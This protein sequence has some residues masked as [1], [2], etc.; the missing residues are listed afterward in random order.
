[1]LYVTTR[2]SKDAYT[3]RH[4]LTKDRGPDGGFFIP[5]RKICFTGE[6][7][8]SLGEKSFGQCVAE[9]LNRFFPGKLTGW[10]VDF[11]LGRRPIRL[12]AMSHKILVGELFNNPGNS[13]PW[14]VRKLRDLLVPS[15]EVPEALSQWTVIAVRIAL[16]FGIFGELMRRDLA[17]QER[18]FDVAVAVDDFSGPVS[19]FYAKQ[20][21]LPI[22][23]IV[24]GCNENSGVW[25]LL[26]HGELHTGRRPVETG[27]PLCDHAVPASLERLIYEKLGRGEAVRFAET[28]ARKGVY[29]LP[30]VTRAVLGEGFFGAVI[31][32]KRMQ[33]VIRNVHSTNGYELHPYGA[34]AYGAL[35]DFRAIQ[36]EATPA[37]IL[38]EFCPENSSADSAKEKE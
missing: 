4:P 6:E 38:T 14:S 17:D 18:P 13:F 21:G 19:V 36:S 26:H 2:D 7:I 8:A 24:F 27:T 22:G 16:L 30:D 15:E 1:M 3:P 32:Q 37:L 35:Q 20:M 34:L 23:R 11:A 28:V 12:I 9:V 25:D 5:F 10:Q 29:A 31:S 33:S